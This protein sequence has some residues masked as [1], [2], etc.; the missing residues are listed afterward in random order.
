MELSTSKS[1]EELNSF[2]RRK[3]IDPLLEQR[4]I[5]HQMKRFLENVTL[6]K[7]G[8]DLRLTSQLV[9]EI[10]TKFCPI[11]PKI[12]KMRL[13]GYDN[14]TL[15]EW[16]RMN[17][18]KQKETIKL[19]RD[20]QQ[21]FFILE[22]EE[23]G[24][25][26]DFDISFNAKSNVD[27]RCEGK[28]KQAG[29]IC[30]ELLISSLRFKGEQN[31]ELLFTEKDICG[32]ILSSSFVIAHYTIH[33]IEDDII[34]EI[35]SRIKKYKDE[36]Y[37]P[38]RFKLFLEQFGDPEIR[39]NFL[40]NILY[41]VK[42]YYYT[43]DNMTQDL[44]SQIKTLPFRDDD[45]LIFIILNELNTKSQMF[46][47]YFVNHYLDFKSRN[48]EIKKSNQ[49]PKFLSKYTG[50]RRL[51]LIFIEDVIGTGRQFIKFYKNDFHNQYKKYKIQ[52]NS[53]FK[54]YLVAGIGSEQSID[55]ISNNS[56]LSESHIRYSR[57]FRENDKAFNREN[58]DNEDEMENVKE[59]LKN[60]HPKR[61]GGYMRD[62]T[63]EGLQ[64]LIVLEWNTPNNTLGCL[65]KK[66]DKWHPLFT[67]T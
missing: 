25:Y 32:Y 31:L 24:K 18:I 38:I 42:D 35:N 29:R 36:N 39:F 40:K 27:I 7:F 15:I 1:S 2:V 33:K 51:F 22:F 11:P 20:L 47:T 34:S 6:L 49:I 63:E 13:L 48:I 4:E 46:W 26:F 37:N 52:K 57:I 41:R 66:N 53:N 45:E 21:Y 17:K 59:F 65:Y 9:C 60:I 8:T 61:W 43:F 55:F 12:V 23:R 3:L 62:D 10:P 50:Q 44:V 67:R 54:F 58:W 30:Y 16:D 64:Y 28:R 19:S 14:E 5:N 56:I